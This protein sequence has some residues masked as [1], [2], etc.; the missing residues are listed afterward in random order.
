MLN[1]RLRLAGVTALVVVAGLGLSAVAIGQGSKT[2]A[3]PS[4]AQK[5]KLQ[6]IVKEYREV[7]GKLGK[8]RQ[9]TFDANPKLAK[10]RDDFQSLV[11]KRMADN[12]YDPEDK[13]DH[14]KDLRD[15]LQ[16][17]DASKAERQQAAAEFRKERQALQQAQRKALKDPKVRKAGK[18]LRQDTLVAMK[19]QDE[20]TQDLLDRLKDL[21]Q[22]LQQNMPESA[23][24]SGK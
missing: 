7:A 20:K 10:Q 23:K 21:R 17:K 3:Q 13:A 24:S 12:G 14:L 2:P 16:S 19:A 15:K 22:Q 5:Q 1:H 4:A 8:I 18:K 11:K 9:D 6:S